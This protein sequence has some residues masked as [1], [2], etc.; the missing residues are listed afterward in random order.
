MLTATSPTTEATVTDVRYRRALA[1]ADI[2]ATGTNTVK[3]LF[4]G[5]GVDG[6]LGAIGTW[7][8]TDDTVGRVAPDGSHTDDLGVDI[9]GA[10]GVEVP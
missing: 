3:A 4:V 8:L 7:T 9:Y 1:G 6:P 5:Q 10:F 2:N